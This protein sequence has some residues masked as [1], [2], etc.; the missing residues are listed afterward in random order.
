[1][2]KSRNTT[3]ITL[4]VTLIISGCSTKND[5]DMKSELFPKGQQLPTEWFTGNA[6]LH[7]LVAKDKN[8]AF[9]AVTSHLK[10]AQEPT[11]I[12]IPKDRY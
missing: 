5:N 12:P 7:P 11:G 8:N 1:M 3:I 2:I 10:P 6:F 9:S 4:L